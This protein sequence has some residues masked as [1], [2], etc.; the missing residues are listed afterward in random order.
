MPDGREPGLLS[1]V[2]NA[3]R[4]LKEFSGVDRELGVTEL[5]R[6][7]GLGKSTVHRLLATLASERLLERGG[8][9]GGYRLGLAIY[10]LGAA[11]STHVDLHEAALPALAAL[12]QRTGETVH[13]AVL[14][15]MEVVYVERLDS[16]HLL[17]IFSRVGHRLPAPATSTGKVLLAALPPDV[18]QA[19]LAHWQPVRLTS[20]TITDA[21]VL[22]TEL[23]AVAARGWAENVEEGEFGVASVGAPVR[24]A[25]GTVIAAVSVAGPIARLKRTSLRRFS[26]AV[27]EAADVIS[28]RL[29]YRA[30]RRAP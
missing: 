1:S 15:G 14:D 7:L 11:V 26:G 10:E 6:R 20:H 3:A 17:R 4:V 22:R 2:R 21:D 12:R 13:V 8:T 27:L 19:R 16:P 28:R 9:A 30:P 18:L 29:G 23:A 25:D 5:S 24:G